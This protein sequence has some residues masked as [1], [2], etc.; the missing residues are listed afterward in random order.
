MKVMIMAGGTGGHIFPAAAVA[1]ALIAQGHQIRWLGSLNGMEGKVVPSMGYEFCGLPVTAWYGG[2][3][4]KLFAPINLFRALVSCL[5]IFASEKPDAVVG[6]GGYASAPGGIAAWLLKTPLILH[7]QNGVPGLTNKKLE[8]K[9]TTVLQAFPNTF[10]EPYE[11]V[12][13]PVRQ[14]ICNV[15]KPTARKVGQHKTLRLL[16]LGGSQ[17]AEVINDTVPLA[18]SQSRYTKSIE[19]WHQAGANKAD[20]TASLYSQHVIEASVVEFIDDMAKAYQWCDLVIARSGAS[21]VSEL[22]AVGTYSILIPYPWHKDRQQFK[23]AQW[24][25]DQ[26]C[27]ECIEQKD[28][29]VESLMTKID[30]WFTSRSE[31]LQK[32]EQTWQM[33]VRDSAQRI[34]SVINE[35]VTR[36]AA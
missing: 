2:R 36:K 14:A 7:E 26:G 5:R 4:R 24:L 27:A 23:N 30:Y 25:V 22:A 3:L 35:T 8:S 13:N 31:L 33:G 9:A 20:K 19:I 18:V 16:V 1:E 21:T 32:S 10:D 29:T 15:E 28:L 17:G 6:F 11:V 34:V 12:G